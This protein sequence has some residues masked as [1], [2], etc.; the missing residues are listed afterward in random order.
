MLGGTAPVA[1]GLARVAREAHQVAYRL[2]PGPLRRE[3][4]LLAQ[5]GR[6]DLAG[7]PPPMPADPI[8]ALGLTD[9]E[10]QVLRLLGRGY[11]TRQIA[12]EL[13]I[14]VKTAS[15]HVSH[16][17]TKLEVSRRTEAAAIAHRFS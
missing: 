8:A 6:L 3:L 14:S 4:E 9:R 13:T 2:G 7:P 11:T 5:R 15:V 10:C 17:L 12:A 16:I 1:D